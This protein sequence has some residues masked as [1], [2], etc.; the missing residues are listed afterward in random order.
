MID[1]QELVTFMD[2]TTN[3]RVAHLGLT[4]VKTKASGRGLGWSKFNTDLS[5]VDPSKLI[6]VNEFFYCPKNSANIVCNKFCGKSFTR[7]LIY[8]HIFSIGIQY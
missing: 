8:S 6:K 5:M 1:D 4:R 3:L 2:S 7:K